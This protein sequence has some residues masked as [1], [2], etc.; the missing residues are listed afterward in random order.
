MSRR[1]LCAEKKKKKKIRGGKKVPP[2]SRTSKN[3][4][5]SACGN[6]IFFR[7]KLECKCWSVRGNTAEEDAGG[8]QL[9]FFPL[10][11]SLWH[12]SRVVFFFFVELSLL[13]G[14]A[15]IL[16]DPNVKIPYMCGVHPGPSVLSIRPSVH[17]S[18]CLSEAHNAATVI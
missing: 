7:D 16:T 18:L 17:P 6:H 14:R 3:K 4:S 9:L 13:P 2:V 10:L 11:V 15:S 1:F 5:A 12:H 8:A